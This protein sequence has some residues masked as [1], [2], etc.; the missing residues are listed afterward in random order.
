MIFKSLDLSVLIIIVWHNFFTEVTTPYFA[1][2]CID[3]LVRPCCYENSHVK[4]QM[5][6]AQQ[7]REREKEGEREG[8]RE[9]RRGRHSHRER[10][11]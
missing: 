9:R 4:H 7:E 5:K 8:E 6:L 2:T 3:G 11:R 10:Q 1:C